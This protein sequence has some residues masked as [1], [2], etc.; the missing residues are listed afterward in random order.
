[1]QEADAQAGYFCESY[2][3]TQQFVGF[4]LRT[5]ARLWISDPQP[6]LDYYG[7]TGPG[8]LSNVVAYGRIYSS[9]Y[10]GILHCYDMATGKVL[11]T[12]GNGGA[13][14]TTNSGF[15]VPGPYP[16][17]IN[18]IGNGIVYLVTTEHTFETPI[19]KGALA[20]AVNATDGTELWTLSAATGEFSRRKLRNR[21]RLLSTLQQL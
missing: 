20:R 10:S 6:A 12:Y 8:T 4:N 16:T 3:Q 15:Q 7:S 17:F 1:M 19:Y 11:W 5:G 21:R 14:N 9:A 2:R 18:A 13:G